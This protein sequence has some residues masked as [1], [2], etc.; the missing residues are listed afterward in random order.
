MSKRV[1]R[2]RFDDEELKAPKVKKA[3][4]KAD[5]AV[6]NLKKPKRKYQRKCF[7]KMWIN[8]SRHQ[9]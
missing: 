7:T 6:K 8:R 9:S 5:K 2:L 1:P 3:A 4:Q